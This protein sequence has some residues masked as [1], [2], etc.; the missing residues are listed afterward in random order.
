[1]KGRSRGRVPFARVVRLLDKRVVRGN[2]AEQL[3]GAVHQPVEH[4]HADREVRPEHHGPAGVVHH[5]PRLHFVRLPS[6]GPL[7]EG[8]AGG[9]ARG[10]VREHRVR[11]REVDRGFVTPQRGYQLVRREPGVVDVQHDADRVARFARPRL[12]DA[13]HP[14]IAEEGELHGCPTAAGSSSRRRAS[15]TYRSTPRS[16]SALAIRSRAVWA[17][18]IEPGPNSSGLP[19][20]ERWGT[21]VV[22]P[23]THGSKPGTA[24]R[25]TGGVKLR[26]SIRARPATARSSRSRTGAGSPTS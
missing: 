26:Y 18:W 4:V 8:H 7:D 5:T 6:R 2:T 9:G 20:F 10:H 12:D 21:S 25:R 11:R 24:V 1:M 15:R 22:K 13:S 14:A 23:T 16:S 17:S 3:R 19:Q